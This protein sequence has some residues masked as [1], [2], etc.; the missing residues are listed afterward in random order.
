MKNTSNIKLPQVLIIKR[1]LIQVKNEY[2]ILKRANCSFDPNKWEF[3]GG[4]FDMGH[5]V[6]ENLQTEVFEE[7]G[8]SLKIRP[9]LSY[10]ETRESTNPKYKGIPILLVFYKKIL[11]KKPTILLSE[12][13]SEYAWVSNKKLQNYNCSRGT[14]EAI[15]VFL[16]NNN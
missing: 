10:I 11:N 3:P 9:E 4:K 7:T 5:D 8:I 6:K 13:H 14:K 12:E 2:L 16:K 15:N 1:C